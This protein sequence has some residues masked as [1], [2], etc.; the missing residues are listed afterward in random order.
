[1]K[2]SFTKFLARLDAIGLRE[3]I[4]KRSLSFHVSLEEL[5]EGAGRASSISAARREIYSW[6]I[7]EGKSINE[8]ARLF[9]RAPN[10]VWKMTKEKT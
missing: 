6:L 3:K 8:V 5:Y 9:D 4:E 10:G 1:M 7:Q 2:R